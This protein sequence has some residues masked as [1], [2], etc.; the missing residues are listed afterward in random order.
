[1][2]AHIICI[3]ETR[4]N[5]ILYKVNEYTEDLKYGDNQG[6]FKISWWKKWK[7]KLLFHNFMIKKQ[8]KEKLFISGQIL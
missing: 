1:M 6:H 7:V 2:V 5:S 4:H 8:W 3:I